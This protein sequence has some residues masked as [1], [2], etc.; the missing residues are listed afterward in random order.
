MGNTEKIGL[1]RGQIEA[2]D[3]KI[4]ALEQRKEALSVKLEEIEN[5]EIR[6]ALGGAGITVCEFGSLIDELA[7]LKKKKEAGQWK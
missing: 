7:V 1:L 2:I 5:F 3:T 4:E 6:A